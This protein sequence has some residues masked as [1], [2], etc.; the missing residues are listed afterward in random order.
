MCLVTVFISRRKCVTS[1]RNDKPHVRVRTT[2]WQAEVLCRLCSFLLVMHLC[3]LP[4]VRFS[5]EEGL[6]GS[7]FMNMC[8]RVFDRFVHLCIEMMNPRLCQGCLWSECSFRVGPYVNVARTNRSGAFCRPRHVKF[9][10]RVVAVEIRRGMVEVLRQRCV[11]FCY[12]YVFDRCRR[13]AT[14]TRRRTSRASS[15]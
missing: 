1:G 3:S 7:V 12:S 4:Q 14:P 9:R 8:F 10:S 2:P 6:C 15:K 11:R 13:S 5:Y